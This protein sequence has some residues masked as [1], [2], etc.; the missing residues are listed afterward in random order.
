MPRSFLH[1]FSINV[2]ISDKYLSKE[3]IF[4]AKQIIIQIKAS[5]VNK[6]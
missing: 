4:A 6:A 1:H 3:N 2:H 5:N